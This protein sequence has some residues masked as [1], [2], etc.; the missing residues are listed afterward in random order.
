MLTLERMPLRQLLV[1][2]LRRLSTGVL[3]GLALSAC[4]NSER[5][6][7]DTRAVP[8]IADIVQTQ[9]IAL[10]LEQV[11]DAFA[12]GSNATDLQREMMQ[13][14]LVGAVVR[15][16]ITVYEIESA[17]G[18]KFKVISEPSLTGGSQG[19]SLLHVQAIVTPLSDADRKMITALRT[20]DNLVIKGRVQEIVLRSAVVIPLA[21]LETAK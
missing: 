21:V 9:P 16:R 5:A 20:G 10:T 15:W 1:I 6:P 11:S 13:N 14:E 2:N 18:G 19:L 4:E 7:A 12:L 3:L 8:T 17:E